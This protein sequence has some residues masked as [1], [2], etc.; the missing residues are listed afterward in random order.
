[1]ILIDFSNCTN[2]NTIQYYY[3]LYLLPIFS[4]LIL[5]SNIT[6]YNADK[7]NLNFIDYKKYI[8]LNYIQR[9]WLIKTKLIIIIIKPKQIIQIFLWKTLRRYPRFW[10]GSI[11]PW[12]RG[13]PNLWFIVHNRFRR[14]IRRTTII[15]IVLYLLKR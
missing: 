13:V 10:F 12:I 2:I 6:F 14:I 11:L 1:M 7:C 4:K 5:I 9:I 15:K 8:S 3:I